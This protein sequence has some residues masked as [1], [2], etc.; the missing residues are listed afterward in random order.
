VDCSIR[1]LPCDYQVLYALLGV[2]VPPVGTKGLV[3]E[4]VAT[5]TE[6]YMEVF[7]QFDTYSLKARV[8]PALISGLPLLILLFMLVPWD[9][10]ALSQVIASSIGFV[11][12]FA[13]ADLA[14]HRGKKL[15][16]RLG[17]GETPD[18]W[19]RGNRDVPEGSKDRYRG[20]VAEQLALTAPTL[21]EEQSGSELSADFY[22]SANAWLREQTRDHSAYPLLFAENITYGFRRNLLGLKSIA[23]VC[24]L[25][26]L[27][28]CAGI[29]Y[30]ESGYFAAL[31]NVEEKVYI[32]VAA[33]L[34]H[35]A[36]LMTA[37]NELAL[38]E[39][40]RAYGRQL[41][42]SCESLM[43]SHKSSPPKDESA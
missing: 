13:F 31:P 6:W 34:L 28:S 27:L 33:A 32:A 20:F 43:H 29:L 37:V 35:S 5:L 12:I 42:L 14:R 39:A 24:N 36:Y 25:L 15:Q 11:L 41:I 2:L 4:E 3:T 17:T 1:T 38:R 8:F 23:L 7:S 40:S 21:E 18:Q 22:Q 26:V 30:F 10:L 9:H 16:E 19:L